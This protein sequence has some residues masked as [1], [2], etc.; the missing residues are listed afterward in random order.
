MAK[1]KRMKRLAVIVLQGPK[2]D[3]LLLALTEW[4]DAGGSPEE[5]V[6]LIDDLIE[7]IV[8]SYL[9]EGGEP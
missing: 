4:R 3:A 7:E 1:S 5:V 9:H 2:R 6:W 8:L